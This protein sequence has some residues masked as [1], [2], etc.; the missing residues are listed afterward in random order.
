MAEYFNPPAV[1]QPFGAFSMGVVHGAGHVVRLKGQV[2]LDPAGNVVGAEDMPAQLG[3]TLENIRQT[4]AYV[5]GRMEDI[6]S[7]VQHTTDI[8][9]FMACGEIRQAY[10][11]PPYPVTTTVEV[12]R[13]YDQNLMIEITATAE[14]PEDRFISP[15]TK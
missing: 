6:V 11:S 1:W 13:L 14:I 3:Q 12:N 10:F 5:G 15:S 8:E 7:L 2:A 4:L 9:A